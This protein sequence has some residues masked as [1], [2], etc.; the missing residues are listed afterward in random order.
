MEKDKEYDIL[1]LSDAEY[2][3]SEEEDAEN[4][5]GDAL[6]DGS[7]AVTDDDADLDGGDRNYGENCQKA[8]PGEAIVSFKQFCQMDTLFRQRFSTKSKNSTS[9]RPSSWERD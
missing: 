8:Q 1:R 9:S 6:S 7:G 2:E 4:Y 5:D 3:S